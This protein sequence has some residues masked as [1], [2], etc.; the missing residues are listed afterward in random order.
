MAEAQTEKSAQAQEGFQVDEF[1]EL[2]KKE[3]KP[4]SDRAAQQVEAAVQTL[5]KQVLSDQD[6]ILEDA[7][8][9]INAI[10]AEIDLKLTQQVNHILHHE[11]FQKL[12][13]SWRGGGSVAFS[14]GASERAQCRAQYRRAS[15][16]AYT[17]TATCATP[18]GRATQ[19]ATLRRVGDNTYQGQFRNAEYDVSGTISVTVSG[20]RQSVRLSGDTGS[21]AFE[22]RR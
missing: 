15:V 11:S 9:S 18:S 1:S 19:T 16:N 4:K 13:G 7:V 6:L 12:E 2:L 17:V 8:N 10:I 22:L 5:A 21:A 20:N 3:F 14:S